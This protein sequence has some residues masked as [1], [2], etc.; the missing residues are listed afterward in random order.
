MHN[1]FY[2]RLSFRVHSISHW[3]RGNNVNL[4]LIWVNL[5]MNLLADT[6]HSLPNLSIIYIMKQTRSAA[7]LIAVGHSLHFFWCF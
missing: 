5:C 2:C 7:L 6:V 1:L 4:E 3:T